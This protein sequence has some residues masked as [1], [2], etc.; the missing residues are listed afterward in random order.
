MQAFQKILKKFDRVSQ[1]EA[2]ATCMRFSLCILQAAGWKAGSVYM[3][4][5]KQHHWST[6]NDVER[7]I[8]K[9]EVKYYPRILM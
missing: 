3:K 6:C 7:M 9:T 1:C 2:I 5:V 4:K 8:E